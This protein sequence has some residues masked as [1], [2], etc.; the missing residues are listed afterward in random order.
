MNLSNKENIAYK[1]L[2]ALFDDGSFTEL[3]AYAKSVDGEVEVVSG[4]G[5]VNGAECYAF[6]QNSEIN[7]GAVSVAHCAKISKVYSLAT[8]TVVLL[9]EYMT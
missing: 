3:D 4:F 6:A 2:A 7:S 9:S 5:Y 8:K 1:R